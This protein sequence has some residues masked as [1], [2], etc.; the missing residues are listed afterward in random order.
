MRSAAS[1]T[2]WSSR[3]TRSAGCR[4]CSWTGPIT[5]TTSAGPRW[6]RP[7]RRCRPSRSCGSRCSTA[8]GR[9]PR[10]AGSSWPGRD[11]GTVVLPDADLKIFLDAS[12]EERARRRTNE[13]GLDP[14]V[15]GGRRHPRR[16]APARRAR[17]DPGGRPAPGR[18]RR[19]D[20]LDRR[21][22]VRGH[23]RRRRQ[24][25]PRC[26]GP[27]RGR[28]ASRAAPAHERPRADRELD[29]P[30]HHG[31]DARW[32]RLRPGDEPRSRSR[33]RSTR[34]PA[35]ARSSS[36]RTTRPTS[37]PSSSARGSCRGSGGA[38]TGSARRSCS[39]GRSSAGR[40]ANGGVHPVDRGAAD[41]EAFRLA[42]RIL[43]EGNI[44]FVFPE[45][46]RSPDGGA[47]AGPG[48]R[49]GPRAADRARRS[50][51]SGSPA[52]TASGRRARSCRTR[53]VTSR[54]ASGARSVP[55]TLLPP[56]TDRRTAKGLATDADHG[57]HRGAPAAVP[58]RR[59]RDRAT[60]GGARTG[61][62]CTARERPRGD[63]R[64]CLTPRSEQAADPYRCGCHATLT[65]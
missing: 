5:P 61:S 41:V 25:D 38:S 54:S 18:V 64:V 8:S 21:Q 16:P 65:R 19:P 43:D 29:H 26:R 49:R 50:S 15:A 2:R 30:A 39:T 45:G 1:W 58:A 11:I 51:R 13:R 46:T 32:A 22:P 33:V 57:A 6:M 44:L 37:T 35:R 40:R 42:Q 17:L 10:R 14:A 56:G 3:R 20:H 23:G 59:L 24:R 34:S 63:P 9:S 48:R 55:P 7:S 31:A 60:G 4:A 27:A 36:P 62:R 28:T 53:A 12:V 47:P 52:R